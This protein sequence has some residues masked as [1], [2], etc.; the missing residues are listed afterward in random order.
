MRRFSLRAGFT[1]IELM[2]VV[3]IIGILAAVMFPAMSRFLSAGD[4]TVSRNNLR[5]LGQ[6]AMTYRVDHGNYWPAS[7]GYFTHFTIIS[8]GGLQDRYGRARGWV[9]FEHDCPREAGDLA[10][11]DDIGD[12]NHQDSEPLA[13]IGRIKPDGDGYDGEYVN[14]EGCCLC[15]DSKSDQGGMSSKPANWQDKRSDVRSPAEV[16]ILNGCL[17][18]Y[19]GDLECFTNPAFEK[20]AVE[21]LGVARDNI[22][23]AYAMNVVCGADEDLYDTDHY[24]TGGYEEAYCH[25]GV[26]HTAIRLGPN[27]LRPYIDS[28]DRGTATPGQTALFVELDVDNDALRQ[29]NSLAGD[30]VWDWDEGDESMGFIHDDNGLRY[31]HVCFA[32]GHV[33]AIRDPSS[34]SENPDKTKR[35]RLSKWY[36]SGGLSASG[37]KLD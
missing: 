35:L 6:A 14:E 21:K 31:A 9:Y 8:N 36:G 29:D 26:R 37:E 2:V 20:L 28:E 18:S 1:M 16:A 15:F 23:R 22:R 34:D 32:D 11:E 4:D 10:A 5:R 33:E 19:V 3:V 17:Y 24:I 13:G 7:G 30:Q 12:G 27:A 25:P